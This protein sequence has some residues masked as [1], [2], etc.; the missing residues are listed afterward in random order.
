MNKRTFL[1]L[2]AAILGGAPGA[3]L[4]GQAPD[5]PPARGPLTNWA[6]NYRYSTNN[7]YPVT[8]IEQ[9]Q[10]FVKEH[11][12]LKTLG[13][14]HCFNGIA[15]SSHALLSLKPMNRVLA[16]D[17]MARTVTVE[18]GINYGQLSPYLHDKGFA[19]HNLASLPHIS[20]AGAC[21]TATHGSG[22]KSGNLAT[23]VSALELVTADGNVLNLSR[24]RDGNTFLGAV[25]NLGALGVV[26]KVTLDIEPTFLMRQ[27]V[28]ENMTLTQL[29]DHFEAIV[30][31]GDSVSLFTDWQAKRISEVWVKRRVEAGDRSAAKPEFYGATLATK[32]LHPIAELSAE[33]CTE[34]MG[35]PGPWYERL[36]H[37]RMGFTPSS[38]K[39]LQSEYFVARKDAVEA[40]LAIERLRDRVSPHL[41]ISELRT[42]EADR[43]WMSPC[44]NQPSLS[45]HFTWKPDWDAVR[46]LLP[47]I[48]K[49]LAPFKPRPHWGKLF[50]L[51]PAQLQSR[52]EKLNDFKGLV[53]THDPL[54]KF[55]NAFLARNLYG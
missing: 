55:R 20:I 40:I 53:K 3:P 42:I 36:P 1:K 38:G 4:F 46:K 32:N 33:N 50:T 51:D 37:F 49:E 44:Y 16:L 25:V 23:A 31:S 27:D 7:L 41:L 24:E 8:S 15:D 13:T 39:E 10:K 29:A 5:G 45:I 22:V 48:E 19:L 34:Q 35:V 21:A 9:I 17:P 6:G 52:Y 12:S 2:S 28:Y 47:M 18:A 30:A 11:D 54:G 43:L 14:R 26:T